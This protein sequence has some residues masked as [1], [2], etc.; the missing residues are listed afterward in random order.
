[1]LRDLAEHDPIE[2]PEYDVCIVGTGPAGAVLASAL[3]G[4]GMRIAVLES[5]RQRPT[6]RADAL[7]AIECDGF[8]VKEWSRERVL[9]GASTT[10]AGLSSA[11]D[12]IDFGARS[13]AGAEGWPIARDELLPFYE[14]AARKHRFPA[15][16]DFGSEGFGR[17]R[18]KG[19][20]QPA[21]SKL[22]EKVFLARS[23]PQ[24]FGRACAATG[25]AS[26]VEL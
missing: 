20:L 24:D 13:W 5:G 10:W 17:L 25:S 23:E 15:F 12:P 16:A 8:H 1:M 21:W 18:A 11:L 14:E 7:R 4:S 9:G 3:V 6:A 19:E 26:H 22:V 2:L